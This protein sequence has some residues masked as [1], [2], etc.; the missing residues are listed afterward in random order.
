MCYAAVKYDFDTRENV[1]NTISWNTCESCSELRAYNI[2]QGH[3]I[4][5]G[6]RDGLVRANGIG[7]PDG[8][9]YVTRQCDLVWADTLA[10]FAVRESGRLGN[11]CPR[12]LEIPSTC[13]SPSPSPSP[14]ASPSP[15]PTNAP[16]LTE[17]GNFPRPPIG[18]CPAWF[19]DQ[20][21]SMHVKVSCKTKGNGGRR[22]TLDLTQRS[23]KPWME[24]TCY[25]EDGSYALGNCK[26]VSE[27]WRGC[28]EP[29]YVDYIEDERG[30]LDPNPGDGIVMTIFHPS[31]GY[32]GACDKITAPPQPGM[33]NP[34]ENYRCQDSDEDGSRGVGQ[35]R[36]RVCMPDGTRCVEGVY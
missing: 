25:G 10:P 14:S 35:T 17:S 36:Y 15:L 29:R 9:K 13:P 4:D 8:D 34:R 27:M 31:W 3:W 21:F 23:Q 19:Q 30:D 2:R 16:P 32:F 22:C 11:I 6:R 24:H 7:A 33:T 26:P 12:K 5:E 20:P 28:Q 1:D 18:T